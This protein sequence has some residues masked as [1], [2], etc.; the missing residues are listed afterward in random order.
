VGAIAPSV[1]IPRQL[2]TVKPDLISRLQNHFNFLVELPSKNGN[3]LASYRQFYPR[4]SGVAVIPYT[5]T[6]RRNV[7][8]PTDENLLNITLQKDIVC[9]VFKI[10]FKIDTV[11]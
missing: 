3:L 4:Y 9:L 1:P 11:S 10:S 5:K 7:K 2:S 6:R 8:L